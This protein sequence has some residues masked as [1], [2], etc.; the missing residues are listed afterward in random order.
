MNDK[1]TDA[2]VAPLSDTNTNHHEGSNDSFPV[3]F[4]SHTTVSTLSATS[5]RI[6]DSR[7][8]LAASVDGVRDNEAN[9]Y[10]SFK[11]HPEIT[12]SKSTKKS[13]LWKFFAHFDAVY[14]PTMQNHHICLVCHEKGVDK[15]ISIGK[16]A[17]TGPLLGHL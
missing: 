11:V 4:M 1:L 14:H 10:V 15:S 17:S 9:I 6:D 5:N 7:P 3:T 16:S 12:Y 8:I 2:D 13:P